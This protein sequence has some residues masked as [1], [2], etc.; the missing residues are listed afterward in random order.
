MSY[1][2]KELGRRRA[3]KLLTKDEAWRIAANT[4]TA[5]RIDPMTGEQAAD[6]RQRRYGEPWHASA[7]FT[8][9]G[10]TVS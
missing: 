1:Y 6:S 3:A 9:T 4:A 7:I 5:Q 2:E 10:A 8:S